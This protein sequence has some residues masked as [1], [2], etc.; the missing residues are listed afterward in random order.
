M[1]KVQIPEKE[2]EMIRKYHKKVNVDGFKAIHV[3]KTIEK[4]RQ[5]RV[6]LMAADGISTGWYLID[7]SVKIEG[8]NGACYA[9]AIA[10]CPFCGERL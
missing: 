1:Y 6:V 3:C 10:F 8:Q 4:N 5:L 2:K 7:E 9:T